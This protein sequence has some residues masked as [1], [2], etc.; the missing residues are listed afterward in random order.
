MNDSTLETLFEHA[1]T[2]TYDL[3]MKVFKALSESEKKAIINNGFDG[4]H[5]LLAAAVGGSIELV[6]YLMTRFK[7]NVNT[8]SDINIENDLIKEATLLWCGCYY[9]H[10][11]LVKFL[12]ARGA[13]VNMPTETKS[14]PLRFWFFIFLLFFSD[15]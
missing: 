8:K 9:G 10:F 15:N 4:V 5:V 11:E 7:L 3:F 12:I 2:G 13:D 1:C 6:D 14:T